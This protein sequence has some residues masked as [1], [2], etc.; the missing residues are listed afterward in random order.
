MKL[1]AGVGATHG[2]GD[3]VGDDGQVVE[4]FFHEQPDDAVGV[5]D[6]V[7]AV[8]GFVADHA[9]GISEVGVYGRSRDE[10]EKSDELGGLGED[11]DILEGYFF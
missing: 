11:V 2:R 10:R 3:G 8:G 1:H 7:R 9:G 5:E 4:P 6:E